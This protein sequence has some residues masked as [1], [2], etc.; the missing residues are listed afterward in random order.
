MK[1]TKPCGCS[2]KKVSEGTVFEGYVRSYCDA[3]NPHKNV[4]PKVEL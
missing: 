2:Y 3:H 1:V 4:A